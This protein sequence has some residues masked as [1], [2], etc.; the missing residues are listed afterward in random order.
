MEK[1]KLNSILESLERIENKLLEIDT[2]CDAATA[3]ADFVE[4]VYETV[5][6][7]L[8]F[9]TSYFSP[10]QEKLPPPPRVSKPITGVEKK[11]VLYLCK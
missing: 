9:I 11:K 8:D 4:Q 3:H 10:A 1:E 2:K 7:P 6:S 5:R